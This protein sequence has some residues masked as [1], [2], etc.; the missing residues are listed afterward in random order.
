MANRSLRSTN[1]D[2][3]VRQRQYPVDQFHREMDTLFDR[4]FGGGLASFGE[5]MGQMRMWDFGMTE[6]EN[7]I[8]VRAEMPGFDEKE[9]D[10]RLENDV[11]TIRAEKEQKGE[12]REEYR[13][14]FR[15]V[16]VPAAID[17][18][19]VKASYRNGVLE[20]HIPRPEQSKARRINVQGHPAGKDKG[21]KAEG[22]GSPNAQGAKAEEKGKK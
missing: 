5:D 12:G 18:E 6:N 13:S 20:L 21:G 1:Q 15:Q 16:S 3:G 11:L 10:V 2:R 7:E 8:V 19:K 9:L 14:F 17:A 22:N 4:F